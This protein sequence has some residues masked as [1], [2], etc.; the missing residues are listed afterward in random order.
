MKC[1]EMPERL[2]SLLY[3]ELNAE[4]AKAIQAH[5][6]SC[7]E[8]R[9]VFEELRS[10]TNLLGEWKDLA[11]DRNFVFVTEPASRWNDWKERFR[12][13]GRGRRLALGM[14]AL[15]AAAL[16]FFA[17]LN[18]RVEV[19]DGRWSAAFSLL[20]RREVQIP[21]EQLVEALDEVQS[22]TLRLVS[23]MIENSEERQRQENA[24]VLTLLAQDIEMQRQRD[25]RLV[26]QG[27]EGL[28]QSTDG[29]FA[30]TSDVLNDLIKLTSYKLERR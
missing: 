9:R 7:G 14:P 5:L 21:R 15:A 23:G 4:E 12:R 11:P 29:R 19:Q 20:P 2:V 30:R 17:V 10:T 13:L 8:C 27:I 22:E 3:G 25:L 28:Q 1:K 24:I 26:G 16:L 6:D 18:V